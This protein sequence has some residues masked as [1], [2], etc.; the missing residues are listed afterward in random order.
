MDCRAQQLAALERQRAA[1]RAAAEAQR[2][3]QKSRRSPQAREFC[4]AKLD[5]ELSLNDSGMLT[6]IGL[7]RLCVECQAVVQARPSLRSPADCSSR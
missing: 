3:G 6:D 4:E 1:I 2:V 5:E 7:R